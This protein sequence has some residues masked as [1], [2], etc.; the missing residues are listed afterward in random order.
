[1]TNAMCGTEPP[2]PRGTTQVPV[3]CAEVR[4]AHRVLPFQGGADFFRPS[5][6]GVA[7]GYRVP[8][9][10]ARKIGR[11]AWPSPAQLSRQPEPPQ[12]T[13]PWPSSSVRHPRC[14]H[15]TNRWLP[16]SSSQPNGLQ[17]IHPGR[18]RANALAPQPNGPQP[19]SPWQ[20]RA[21][22]LAPQPKGPQLTSPGQ[23]PGNSATYLIRP[24]RAKPSCTHRQA[25][26]REQTIASNVAEILEA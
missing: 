12:C 13:N 18:R 26:D 16:S 25:R 4:R 20:R 19:T 5:S 1:M 23:R 17:L 3:R 21:N 2:G 11:R 24:E 9:P 10:L 8:A 14:F 22:T 7:L 15:F 6:Q